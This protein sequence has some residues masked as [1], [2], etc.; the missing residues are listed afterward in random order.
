[1]APGA[2]VNSPLPIMGS[3]DPQPLQPL[4]PQPLAPASRPPPSSSEPL[5]G[6]KRYKMINLVGDGTYGLVY[7]AFNQVMRVV[8]GSEWI[9]ANGLDIA[10]DSGE[11]RDQDDEEEVSQLERGHG[12]QGGQVS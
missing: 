9:V 11:G 8:A 4:A 7:L 5:R 3:E 1:M 6:L 12:P 10:G 2:Q